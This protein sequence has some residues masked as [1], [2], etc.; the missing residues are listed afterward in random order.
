MVPVHGSLTICRSARVR[1]M[2]HSAYMDT[3]YHR[4]TQWTFSEKGMYTASESIPRDCVS[5]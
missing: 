1:R 4:A 5:M 3:A 2:V